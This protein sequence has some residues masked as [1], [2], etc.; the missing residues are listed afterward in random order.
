MR[1][2]AETSVKVWMAYAK[3]MAA[4][5]TEDGQQE[6]DPPSE[7]CCGMTFEVFKDPV[8]TSDGHTYEY[9]MISKWLEDNNT[10]PSTNQVL[11]RKELA[12]NWNLRGLVNTWLQKTG[13]PELQPSSLETVPSVRAPQN[14]AQERAVRQEQI[15]IQWVQMLAEA[16]ERAANRQNE[17]PVQFFK[18]PVGC[19]CS[20]MCSCI[21][22]YWVVVF[23]PLCVA[24]N[25]TNGCITNYYVDPASDFDMMGA[26]CV[27]VG[28]TVEALDAVHRHSSS[29][30]ETHYC[31]DIWEFEFAVLEGPSSLPPTRFKKPWTSHRCKPWETGFQETPNCPCAETPQPSNGTHPYEQGEVGINKDT[32]LSAICCA[33]YLYLTP[34]C[35][36]LT[37]GGCMLEITKE[38]DTPLV[39]RPRRLLRKFL[40]NSGRF[41]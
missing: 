24:H 4:K 2:L 40:E 17:E 16:Q 41:L 7:M 12:I 3:R 25:I 30:N 22:L 1:R 19:M 33:S 31:K 14:E 37:A 9:E 38:H 32:R 6:D 13:K 27:V 8:M 15:Q 29:K 5:R 10:S 21:W 20:S 36:L 11:A 35:A 18:D 34:I 39:L 23:A 26:S 28:A